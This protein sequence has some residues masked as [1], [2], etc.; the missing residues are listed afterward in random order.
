M[1]QLIL[2]NEQDEELGQIE[3]LEAHRKG[4]C[5]RAFS[6]FV[7]RQFDK[8]VELL[9]QQREAS[10]YH[11]GGL[12]TNTCCGHPRPGEDIVSAGER[13][14]HEEMGLQVQLTQAGVFHYIA[15]FENGLTENEV[16]HV[17]IGEYKGQKIHPNPIEVLN[18]RWLPLNLLLDELVQKP[19][20]YTPWFG[21]ALSIALKHSDYGKGGF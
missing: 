6:V 10:K 20:D 19:D 11:C 15:N 16:D 2:V 8:Q 1:E 21:P 14:L 13:R 5:H 3:K 12:W 4:L 18:Y 17:L 7:F 9:L